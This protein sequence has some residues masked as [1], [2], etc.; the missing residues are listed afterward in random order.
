MIFDTASF[1]IGIATAFALLW[2]GSNI[3]AIA[4]QRRKEAELWNRTL[5]GPSPSEV[6]LKRQ[7]AETPETSEVEEWVRLKPHSVLGETTSGDA[8]N[9]PTS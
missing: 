1:L 7:I 8:W 3:I 2:L 4:E 9:G 5:S 6:W